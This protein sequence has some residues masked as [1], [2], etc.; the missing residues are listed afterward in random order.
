MVLSLP[1]SL[2]KSNEKMSSGED[3]I[4]IFIDIYIYKCVCVYIYMLVKIFQLRMERICFFH[5][6]LTA[7]Q[8]K[9]PTSRS[10]L[11]SCLNKNKKKIKG[12]KK[13]A[14]TFCPVICVPCCSYTC[15]PPAVTNPV[16]P[17][18]LGLDTCLLDS[19][20]PCSFSSLIC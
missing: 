1:S 6:K 17:V 8:R 2:S 18:S 13:L 20:R 19:L 5:A 11:N 10:H 3:K 9:L 7:L 12:R 4:Y 16:G 14:Q 15:A